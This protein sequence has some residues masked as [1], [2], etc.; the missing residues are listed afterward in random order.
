MIAWNVYE[1]NYLIQRWVC[2]DGI[3]IDSKLC[4]KLSRFLLLLNYHV[5]SFHS[6]QHNNFLF[7]HNNLEIL[8]QNLLYWNWY[9]LHRSHLWHKFCLYFY[10]RIFRRFDLDFFASIDLTFFAKRIFRSLNFRKW[11]AKIVLRM[12][13]QLRQIESAVD[14]VRNWKTDEID[15]SDKQNS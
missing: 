7:D 4:I 8:P 2:I 5:L 3:E 9:I 14:F 11:F 10:Y 13:K 1:E 12:I 15:S 6:R